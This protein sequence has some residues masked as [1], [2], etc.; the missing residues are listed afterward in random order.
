VREVGP[1][2]CG[3][4]YNLAHAP[5]SA[6]LLLAL[7]APPR[8]RRAGPDPARPREPAP[9][10]KRKNQKIERLHTEDDGATVDEVRVGG[11]TQSITVQAEGGVPAYEVLP[12]DAGRRTRA[13]TETA[14]HGGA[15]PARLERPPASEHG[16]LHRSLGRRGADAL[17]RALKLGEL[18]DL[19]GIQGGIENTNY[20]VTAEDVVGSASSC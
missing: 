16:G 20:F 19:R 12:N 15:Q 7:A 5:A 1:R 8:G 9:R 2:K 11:Q 17:L 10:R 6:T 3:P 18:R 4:A 13:E 14:R